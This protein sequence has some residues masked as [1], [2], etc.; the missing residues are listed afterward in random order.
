MNLRNVMIIPDWN[1]S[2]ILETQDRIKIRSICGMPLAIVV[3]CTNLIIWLRNSADT[4][5]PSVRA[6]SILV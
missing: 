6:F 1:P 5:T 3:K 4:P 2:E